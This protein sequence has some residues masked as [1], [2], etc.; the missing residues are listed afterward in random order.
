MSTAPHQDLAALVNSLRLH[1]AE[2]ELA[3]NS[4]SGSGRWKL[5]FD[6][7]DWAIYDEEHGGPPQAWAA[8]RSTLEHAARHDP[9]RVTREVAA[10]LRVIEIAQALIEQET[11]HPGA[12]LMMRQA[13]EEILRQLAAGREPSART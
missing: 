10:D 11:E 9:E 4:A 12:T 5:D 8:H 1:L 6:G 13:G 2:D 7:D 3:A